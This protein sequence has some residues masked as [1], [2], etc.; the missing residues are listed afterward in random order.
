MTIPR[1]AAFKTNSPRM[2]KV[3]DLLM[4]F[5]ATEASVILT[6]ETG[7]GKDVLAYTLHTLSRRNNGPF[8]VIDCGALSD[9]LLESELFGHVKGSFTGAIDERQ[10]LVQSAHGGTLF[11]NE[12]GEASAAFQLRLLSLLQY[13]SYRKVGSPHWVQANV[14]FVAASNKDLPA[15]VK[16]GKFRE[17]LYHRLKLVEIL[18]PP[19]RERLEDLPDL[20]STFV[21][22]SCVEYGKTTDGFTAEA[23][24]ECLSYQWPGNIRQLEHFVDFLVV[25]ADNAQ[26]TR[27]DVRNYIL[28][29]PGTPEEFGKQLTLFDGLKEVL[30]QSLRKYNWNKTQVAAQLGIDRSTLYRRMKK[31]GVCPNR[32]RAGASGL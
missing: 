20:V 13:K 22:R 25:T 7:T 11:L 26:I 9:A 17:D 12:I 2:Q 29:S 21:S 5:A 24:N 6:G 23:L 16:S 27:E 28:T 1:L 3:L 19:L 8:T 10:G 31:Y 30:E 4:K 14:R 18:V 15:L 32:P